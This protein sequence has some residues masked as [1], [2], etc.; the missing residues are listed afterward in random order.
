MK[1]PLLK[2]VAGQLGGSKLTPMYI[3]NPDSS[4]NCSQDT[5]DK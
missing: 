5:Y 4:Q 1:S 2:K 3:I